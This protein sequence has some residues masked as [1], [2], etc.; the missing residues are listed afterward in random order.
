MNDGSKIKKILL[1]SFIGSAPFFLMLFVIFVVV[2]FML[3]IINTENGSSG[4]GMG[5]S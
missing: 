2:L 3:G 5:N 1:G 4:I